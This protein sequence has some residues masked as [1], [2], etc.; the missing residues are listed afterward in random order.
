MSAV[1]YRKYRPDTFADVIGQ[2]H[3]TDAL[4]AALNA[5]R[6]AHAYL[7]SGPRGCGKTTSARIM[8]RCLNCVKGP[9]ANPCGECPSC[10]DLAAGGPGSLDVIEIDA[11]SH[12]GVEDAREMRERAVFAPSR[13]RYRVFIL[14][15]AHMVTV[16]GFN[17][18]LKLVEEPPEHV[19][20]I[21]ATTEPEKVLETIRS[22][23][24][25][26]PFR[27]VSPEVL[28][29]YL[30][31]VCQ[32]E[33]VT[34]EDGVLPLVV[35]AGGGSVRDSLSVLDQLLS[36]REDTKITYQSAVALLGY[37]DTTLLDRTVQALGA[38]DGA[39][40]FA[41]VEEVVASGHDP[42]RFTEDL[43][44]RLRD[45]IIV[46]IAGGRAETILPNLPA[47]QTRLL[48]EHAA[49]WGTRLLS[50]RADT[51]E[52]ALRDMTGTSAPRLQLELLI[53][54]LLIELPQT[55]RAG[56]EVSAFEPMSTQSAPS[57][58]QTANLSSQAASLDVSSTTSANTST[59]ASP[60][61]PSIIPPT[62]SPSTS[63]GTPL[64]TS[65]SMSPSMSSTVPS[66][67]EVGAP[68]SANFRSVPSASLPVA[69]SPAAH[70]LS[71]DSLSSS[72]LSSLN[73]IFEKGLQ[74]LPRSLYG[75]V[76]N[77]DTKIAQVNGQT[78]IFTAK[79]M[80]QAKVDDF[81][82]AMQQIFGANRQ[83]QLVDVTQWQP[84]PTTKIR[85]QTGDK[86]TGLG[87]TKDGETE[88]EQGER[89]QAEPQ[90]TEHKQ[91][92]NKKTIREQTKVEQTGYPSGASSPAVATNLAAA[93]LPNAT[94]SPVITGV[95]DTTTIPSSTRPVD[96]IEVTSSTDSATLAGASAIE[97]ISNNADTQIPATSSGIN[98]PAPTTLGTTIPAT[99]SNANATTPATANGTN[100]T[101]HTTLAN[102][103]TGTENES[104]SL[105]DNS[106][107]D[108]TTASATPINP[109]DAVLQAFQG[110][111][112]QED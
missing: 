75:R 2:E 53:A 62:M 56:V 15:E 52:R 13:D 44:Q 50:R 66:E 42:R 59:A 54:R 4:Q 8:A 37:T 29:P 43:L 3:V 71:T 33:N 74:Q 93:M 72:D 22:R 39:A 105:Q 67:S 92:E 65:L 102:A 96:A 24:H 21:F 58:S 31:S 12:N 9:T 85:E 111:I 103:S 98:T 109:V 89:R 60:S 87:R 17:A 38:N 94:I 84:Q 47:A 78:I 63:S 97:P 35:R 11:A 18:L 6:I 41:V 82:H 76:R 5:S 46:Q 73:E 20:F 107:P 90:K 30:E 112:I 81:T 69:D 88:H 28:V 61:V 27:L 77:A 7:F 49:Q 55:S 25:H 40:A 106:Y 1:L 68:E 45:M 86:P 99:S 26:Y 70:N 51:I 79:P 10:M 57:S 23:T 104:Q 14:D 32:R 95:P 34:I 48:R 110:K 36:G 108:T 100:T 64:A 16:N 19:K 91:A 80:L 83:I 101:N